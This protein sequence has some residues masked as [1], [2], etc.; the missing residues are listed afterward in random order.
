MVKSRVNSLFSYIP[1]LAGGLVVGGIAIASGGSMLQAGVAAIATGVSGCTSAAFVAQKNVKCQQIVATLQQESERQKQALGT[2]AEL[3]TLY[4]Q[5]ELLE[6]EIQK[7]VGQEKDLNQRVAR[8]RAEMPNL[9]DIE[10]LQRQNKALAT[11]INE[12]EGQLQALDT[13]I[14]E[15]EVKRDRLGELTLELNFKEQQ[16]NE[17]AA[18]VQGFERK[19]AELEFLRSSYDVLVVESNDLET[20]KHHLAA[21]VPRLE[22]ER[23]RVL[24]EIQK[25]EA[26]A[27]EA[28]RLR[29]ENSELEAKLRGKKGYLR[30]L[31]HKI[32][33]RE[34]ERA[35]LE[36][37][38]V[39]NNQKIEQQ[40]SDLQDLKAEIQQLEKNR[41]RGLSELR[42]LEA[43]VN[44]LEGLRDELSEVEIQLRSKQK[45]RQEILDIIEQLSR[46]KTALTA[47]I[48]AQKAELEKLHKQIRL[49]KEEIQ[50]IENSTKLAFQALEVPVNLKTKQRRAFASEA[51]F[52]T[53]F[54]GYLDSKGLVFPERM[55][56]AFH[57]SLKVQDISAL[58]ILA[59]I[60]GTGKSEL[61]QAY[62]EF[63][64]APL[65]MLPVQPR[66][67]SPQDLQGFYN[68]IEKKYKPTAL[69]RYLYQHSRDSNLKG[70]IVLVLLDEMNLARVEYY[71]SD[72][73]SKLETRR[74]KETYLELETGSLKLAEKEGKVIIPQ[75]F[76]FVGTMNEDETTQ[77]LS[78]KVLDRANILTFGRPETLKLRGERTGNYTV[79][80]QYLAWDTFAGWIRNPVAGEELT[81]R[82]KDYV[83]RANEI[84][85]NLG[86]PF[87]H[88][89]YQAIAK[90]AV[91]YPNYENSGN[92]AIA[93]QFG[94]KLLP[95]LRGLMVEDT[96]VKPE[97]ERM[98]ALIGELGDEALN[99][100]FEKARCGQ[101]GQ[102][103]WKGMVY[104]ETTQQ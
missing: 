82:V 32:E 65:V 75:E 58:A 63:I 101:Y 21:E 89:V 45:E 90:Y 22:Q 81:D 69:M 76:L 95:K 25:L 85:E 50:E 96:T 14:R 56:N 44:A 37:A 35:G 4:R 60:S 13:Q 67:D 29:R 53:Q 103:Q 39:R 77:S 94:Q 104:G 34:S 11:Q 49:A 47:E 7:L 55:V 59:G 33:Q 38:I 93:D 18:Q 99:K 98:Q 64:G 88:R 54:K 66:W 28:E 83:D 43:K 42:E 19:A 20:R 91:N 51:E 72:F 15:R 27:G 57:T 26:R 46:E 100:A 8:V 17:L 78:D 61:P 6:T 40:N 23:D 16:K 9:E 10:M 92:Q 68:Y 48:T 36:D 30:D 84:M 86:R 97:L 5:R 3:E 102:F 1:S 52:L 24:A 74:N 87:A 12:Q 31:N 73:L 62:A 2:T 41:D 71:F 79:P 70:R 80:T